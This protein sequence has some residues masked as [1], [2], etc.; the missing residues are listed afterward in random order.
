MRLWGTLDISR[1][2]TSRCQMCHPQKEPKTCVLEGYVFCFE[3]IRNQGK[4]TSLRGYSY[5]ENPCI[6]LT[7]G[8]QKNILNLLT[9]Y[10][11]RH[12]WNRVEYCQTNITRYS[13]VHGTLRE[14]P[15]SP[16]P[17]VGKQTKLAGDVRGSRYRKPCPT[18]AP[19]M[20]T[21]TSLPHS[22]WFLWSPQKAVH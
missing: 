2:K 6:T 11:S 1:I 16:P 9:C 13:C 19:W 10:K 14:I 15:K 3:G 20:C 12:S 17:P 22:C 5:V 21:K 18:H 7:Q 8:R 4:T